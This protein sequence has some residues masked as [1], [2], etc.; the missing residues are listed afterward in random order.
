ML[1]T[2]PVTREITRLI[3]T[4]RQDADTRHIS[5]RAF[6]RA[7]LEAMLD[8]I[9]EE[10]EALKPLLLRRDPRHLSP[11]SPSTA[12]WRGCPGRPA[13]CCSRCATRSRRHSTDG[14]RAV[15]LDMRGRPA[16]PRTRGNA[17]L[18]GPNAQLPV[19]SHPKWG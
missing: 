10:R 13:R 2:T 6:L 15:E 5:R 7:E 12:C 14:A 19:T 18:L 9:A 4:G 17:I 3:A 11:Q 16:P 8:V 1:D